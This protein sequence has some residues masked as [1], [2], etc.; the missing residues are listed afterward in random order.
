MNGRN[1]GKWKIDENESVEYQAMES[2]INVN[3]L[4]METHV[5]NCIF[6]YESYF[7]EK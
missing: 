2:W 3:D 6:A 5:E 7:R 1:W 4:L